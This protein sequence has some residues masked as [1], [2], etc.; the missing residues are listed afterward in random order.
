MFDFYIPVII[1]DKSFNVI[2]I[3]VPMTTVILCYQH[4]GSY[5][6]SHLML[7]TLVFL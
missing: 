6:N 1:Y 2:N 4:W 5:D 3:V 7:S